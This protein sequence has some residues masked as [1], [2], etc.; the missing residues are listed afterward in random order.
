MKSVQVDKEYQNAVLIGDEWR[1]VDDVRDYPGH[2]VCVGH[3]GPS[4]KP[5]YGIVASRERQNGVGSG[6]Y[7]AFVGGSHKAKC[8]VQ[9]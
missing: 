7:M 9:S 6:L 8:I 4:L 1:L 3:T 5:R 2:L